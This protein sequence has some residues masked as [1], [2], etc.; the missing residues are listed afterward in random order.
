M[1]TSEPVTG[2]APVDALEMYYEIHGH[3]RP[4]VLLHGAYMT[5][6]TIGGVLPGLAATRRVIAVEQQGHGHTADIDRPITYEQMA[7][8]TAALCAPQG[9]Q[10][11]R[12]RLQHG[13]RVALQL[14]IRHPRLVRRLVVASASLPSDGMHAVALETFPSITPELFAGSPIEEA[15]LRPRPDPGR[16][17]Q[18]R[19]EAQPARLD[20]FAWPG[21]DIRR[22]AAPTLILLGDSDGVRSST[23]SRSSSCLA[24]GS[25]A[26][27]RA[28]R[29]PSS[30]C[31]PPPLISSRPA[32]ACLIA[33]TGC[34]T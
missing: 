31:S 8:D 21:R 18:A 12:P 33:P 24:A 5:I 20:A 28:C 9:R 32:T 4:L 16:L 11:R 22:I 17:P 25:W 27:C 1:A 2:Y 6:D 15:Y 3:G 30:P 34:W 23:R 10:R 29:G 7:D 14:A 13:R 19:R 26:T